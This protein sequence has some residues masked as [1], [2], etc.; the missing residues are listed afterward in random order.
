[1]ATTIQISEDTKK[2]LFTLINQLERKWKKRITYDEA[3]KYLLENRKIVVDKENF[4]K[5]IEK[6]EGILEEGEGKEL[7]KQLRKEDRE[8]ENRL[9]KQINSD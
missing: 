7:L 1:M 3:I 2:K 5:N 8:R 6:F 4:I 9:E